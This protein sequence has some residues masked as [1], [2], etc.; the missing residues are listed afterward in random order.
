[1]LKHLFYRDTLTIL[2]IHA[3]GAHATEMIHIGQAVMAYGGMVAYCIDTVFH[4]LTLAEA[5]K[6]AAFDGMNIP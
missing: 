6:M 5:W 4:Y 1:V 2:G 3:I